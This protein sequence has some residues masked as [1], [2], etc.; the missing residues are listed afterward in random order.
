MQW[1]IDNWFL[2][3]LGGGMIAMHLFGHGSHGSHGSHGGSGGCCNKKAPADATD[4]PVE[5]TT[6]HQ[7]HRGSADA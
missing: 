6:D 3:L 4:T 2:V 5:A 7:H 1:L